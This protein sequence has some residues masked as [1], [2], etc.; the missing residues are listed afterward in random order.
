MSEDP[1]KTNLNRQYPYIQKYP[2]IKKLV[3]K[4][5][6]QWKRIWRFITS[7]INGTQNPQQIHY[8]MRGTYYS[9]IHG[10]SP[11]IKGSL[12]KCYLIKGYLIQVF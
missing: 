2:K 9:I 8:L 5:K 7:L 12:I 6:K 10:V 4:S 3:K 11:L 1:L